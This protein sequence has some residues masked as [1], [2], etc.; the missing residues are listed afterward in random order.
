M[1]PGY[2]T[3]RFLAADLTLGRLH[4]LSGSNEIVD[5]TRTDDF[6]RIHRNHIATCSG[7]VATK[8]VRLQSG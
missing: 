5:E 3:E 2:D 1:K 4:D 8:Y 6:E 7:D